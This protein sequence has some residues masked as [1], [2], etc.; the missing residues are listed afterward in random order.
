MTVRLANSSSDFFSYRDSHR[1][2]GK[3]WLLHLKIVTT[4]LFQRRMQVQQ[5][6]HVANKRDPNYFP[7]VR[8][9]TNLSC[10]LVHYYAFGA[11]QVTRP[12]LFKRGHL[13]AT[14]E[15]SVEFWLGLVLS[16]NHFEPKTNIQLLGYFENIWFSLVE[17]STHSPPEYDFAVCNSGLFLIARWVSLSFFGVDAS[18]ALWTRS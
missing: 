17:Q 14:W 7:W 2:E 1:Y 16:R 8:S 11:S 6:S 18:I 9:A 4:Q 13:F 12:L 3:N 15:Y 5:Y 10:K